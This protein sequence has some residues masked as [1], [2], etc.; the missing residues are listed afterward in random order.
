MEKKPKA[1]EFLNK[2]FKAKYKWSASQAK[3]PFRSIFECCKEGSQRSFILSKEENLSICEDFESCNFLSDIS[4]EKMQLISVDYSISR[5]PSVVCSFSS[6]H[7][8]IMNPML[9]KRGPFK[10]INTKTKPYSEKIP[11][12][13]KWVSENSF[14]V[15][16][17]DNLL[18]EF[19]KNLAGEDEVYIKSAVN[20]SMNSQRPIFPFPNSRPNANPT[21][22]WKLSIGQISEIEPA[23]L[24]KGNLLAAITGKSIRVLDLQ[25]SI[26]ASTLFSYFA[27]F[28][29]VAWSP[30]GTL[31]LAGGEDD[32]IHAW[33]T[34]S[35]ELQFKGLGHTS[36]VSSIFCKFDGF[37]YLLASV[38]HD[39]NLLLWEH[40]LY[41]SIPL[42]D[43]AQISLPVTAN[44]PSRLNQTIIEPITSVQVSEIP[45]EKVAF[46]KESLFIFD[47][48]GNL[49]MWI[50]ING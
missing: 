22:H 39:G 21:N 14:I 44:Y 7:L 3:R 13:S 25:T 47:C 8:L 5:E 27:N 15:L 6:G 31:L 12:F 29:C 11:L 28:L 46:H 35:W 1:I 17:G 24:A 10:W 9:R 30:E 23:P 45:L 19:N 34:T 38:G 42:Q 4:I 49:N 40:R 2:N 33:N 16:F 43:P 20:Q 37:A 32:C 26:L 48:E 50:N 18:W 36:W 41:N